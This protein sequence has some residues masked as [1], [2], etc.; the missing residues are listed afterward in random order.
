MLTNFYGFGMGGGAAQLDMGTG[1]NLSCAYYP[2][3]GV[4]AKT[5]E[6]AGYAWPTFALGTSGSAGY[7]KV[8]VGFAWGLLVPT[9]SQARFAELRA[10]DGSWLLALRINPDWTVSILRGSD[11]A[12]LGTTAAVLGNSTRV[13]V[14][15]KANLNTTT[16]GGD[17]E[18]RFN[19][20]SVLTLPGGLSIASQPATTLCLPWGNFFD[21]SFIDHIYALDWSTAPDTDFLGPCV[22]LDM[23]P[24]A[25]GDENFWDPQPSQY[26]LVDDENVGGH[27]GDSTCV[28]TSASGRPEEYRLATPWT[29]AVDRIL[30]VAVYV[31]GKKDAGESLQGVSPTLKVGALPKMIPDHSLTFVFQSTG[32]QT[33]KSLWATYLDAGA[34][35]AA[36]QPSDLANLQ[37]G[38]V[39]QA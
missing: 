37:G 30:G 36:F 26:T 17:V 9:P 11:Q 13:Y 15:L 24:V 2:L 35:P 5:I 31:A 1:G 34:Q 32:Y 7:R 3:N 19:G 38:Y 25:N 12:V 28:S 10:G 27:D 39:S 33:F 23:P 16:Q 14:E 6:Q 22:V 29:Y 20:Q 21:H 4:G 18:L 8:I